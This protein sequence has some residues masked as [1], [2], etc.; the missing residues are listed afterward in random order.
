MTF[1]DIIIILKKEEKSKTDVEKRVPIFLFYN[2]SF[3]QFQSSVITNARKNPNFS[4]MVKHIDIEL[5]EQELYCPPLT[6]RVVD[7]R[8]VIIYFPRFLGFYFD[9]KHKYR[10]PQIVI[11]FI[12]IKKRSEEISLLR[13]YRLQ[14][15][16]CK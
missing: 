3:I 7:C 8:S 4:M 2:L 10:K 13:L 1:Y 15:V 16:I 5:P 14:I 6:I 12:K 11:Y 9:D